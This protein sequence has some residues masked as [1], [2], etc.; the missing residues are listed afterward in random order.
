MGDSASNRRFDKLIKIIMTIYNSL[1]SCCKLS[2]ARLF[3]LCVR[4]SCPQGSFVTMLLLTHE[5][6]VAEKM[7]GERVR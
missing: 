1:V 4:G 5:Y 6:M 3:C 7:R 2:Q